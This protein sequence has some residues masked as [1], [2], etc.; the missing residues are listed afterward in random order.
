MGVL[1]FIVFFLVTDGAVLLNGDDP[2]ENLTG[3][4]SSHPEVHEIN[5]QPRARGLKMIVAGTIPEEFSSENIPIFNARASSASEAL[6]GV[7]SESPSGD[8]LHG[9]VPKVLY[10]S[11][12]GPNRCKCRALSFEQ[13]FRNSYVVLK[14]K[15]IKFTDDQQ[16]ASKGKVLQYTI[17]NY[18]LERMEVFKSV[19][20][21]PGRLFHAQAFI[22]SDLCGVK[23]QVG[24][25]YLLNLSNPS[26]IYKASA[27]RSGAFVLSSCQQHQNY[28]SLSG[29]QL[30]FLRNEKWGGR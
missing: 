14:A 1:V 6:I 29:G 27:W 28:N 5:S 17:R 24:E 23:L 30:R 11:S 4:P 10:R 19:G 7:G 3:A 12:A 18:I 26:T 8:R 2:M 15:V 25:Q 21:A 20:K 22:Q 9:D 16:H 13:Q